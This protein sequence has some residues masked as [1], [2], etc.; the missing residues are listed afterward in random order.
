LSARFIR[1]VVLA[2]PE[3]LSTLPPREFRSG[4]YEI[5]KY[6]AIGDVKLFEFLEKD[7]GKFCAGNTL[8][9]PLRLSAP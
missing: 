2:D 3:M 9:W 8:L 7:M 1:E 4:I 6:G 5:I